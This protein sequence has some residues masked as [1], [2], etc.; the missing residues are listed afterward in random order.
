MSAICREGGSADVNAALAGAVLGARFGLR[1][2]PEWRTE[3][4]HS[5]WVAARIEEIVEASCPA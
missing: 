2:V 3:L 5:D 4:P 1:A